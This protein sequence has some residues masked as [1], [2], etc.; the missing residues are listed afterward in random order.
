MAR[1]FRGP[2]Q[3]QDDMDKTSNAVERASRGGLA[4]DDDYAQDGSAVERLPMSKRMIGWNAMPWRSK[5][6]MPYIGPR[7]RVI[8]A[9]LRSPMSS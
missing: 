8:P 4:T 7:G 2:M 5:R 3:R 1:S 6:H 9:W